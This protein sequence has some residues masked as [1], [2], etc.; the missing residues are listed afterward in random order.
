MRVHKGTPY[1]QL[2]LDN[3]DLTDDQLLDAMLAHPILINRP[4]VITGLGVRLCRPSEVVL[5]ILSSP[6]QGAFRLDTMGNWL[7]TA[8]V[9]VRTAP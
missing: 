8:E 6:Q 4:F 2:G 1:A 3:L 9:I 7:S 5:D